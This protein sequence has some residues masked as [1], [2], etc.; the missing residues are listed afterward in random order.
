MAMRN[1]RQKLQS[2]MNGKLKDYIRSLLGVYNAVR[3]VA[4]PGRTSD[5]P[6]YRRYSSTAAPPPEARA[7]IAG[8]AARCA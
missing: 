7:G 1:R 5:L 8:I 2:D 6:Y 3:A 4:L